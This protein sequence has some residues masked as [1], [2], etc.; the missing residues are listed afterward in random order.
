MADLEVLSAAI[1]AG[2]RGTATR[3]TAEAIR[4][5]MDPRAIL[6]AM[7][8]AMAE[9]GR[10]FQ[11]NEVYVP[12]MLISARAM[13][14]ATALLEPVLIKAGVRPE[15]T[16]V[17]GTING[18]LHDIGK[19]LVA[20]MWRGANIKVVDLGTNVPA[21]R[22]VQAARDHEASL[23][24]ISALLTTT[25]VGMGDAVATIRAADLRGVRIMVGGAPVTP[26]FAAKIG[27]DAYAPDAASAVGVAK[28]AVAAR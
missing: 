19:N 7:T 3:V 6:D 18:D 10:R 16:A 22:F 11:C 9:V 8:A 12:E 5:E 25:M 4:D 2:D 28:E 17:I 21:E 1:Q 14:E 15:W 26:E 20:M 24:G 13:K 23:I 27:A